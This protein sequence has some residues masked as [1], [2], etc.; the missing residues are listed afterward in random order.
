MSSKISINSVFNSRACGHE[1]YE[2]YPRKIFLVLNSD[3]NGQENFKGEPL[4]PSI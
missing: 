4:L 1:T 3:T 2:H